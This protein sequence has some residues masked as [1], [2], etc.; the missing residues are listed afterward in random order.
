LPVRVI[1]Q[2]RDGEAWIAYIR[3]GTQRRWGKRR[4]RRSSASRAFP[5]PPP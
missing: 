1:Y 3:H 5:V 4:R 2:L